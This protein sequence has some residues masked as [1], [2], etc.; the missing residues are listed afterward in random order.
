MSEQAPTVYILHGEDSY[1]MRQFVSAAQEKL[2]DP[3]MA[4]MNTTRL[5]GNYDYNQLVNAA[6]AMPF[7][8]PR[9]LVVAHNLSS[10]FKGK[11]QQE[12]L[13]HFFDGL[14]QTTALMLLESKPLRKN[15]WLLNWA[16]KAKERA[17][18]KDYSVPQGAQMAQWIR[19][20]TAEQGGQIN[21]Q[22]AGLLAE[23]AGDSPQMASLEI[24]KLLAFVNYNRAIEVEDVDQLAAFAS[25]GGDF[26]KFID[27]LGARNGRTAINMLHKLM[28]EQAALMLFFSLVGQYRML[29]Q[30]REVIE[31]RGGN[32]ATVADAL[33][34]HP[35]RAKKLTAQARNQRLQDLEDIYRQLADYDLEIKTGQTSPELA[36]E[37]LVTQL[38]NR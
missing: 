13:K 29:I 15:S 23:L 14:P 3:A 30:T 22:A 7:L 11:E 35:F 24:D 4:E 17:Y 28:E 12:K 34:I 16:K 27:A 38:T 25:G 18:V 37:T 6:S 20:Y 5:E 9:R 1:A 10:H 32:E 21:P 31:Q 36:L 33:G 19:K 2:G 26:F 8:T